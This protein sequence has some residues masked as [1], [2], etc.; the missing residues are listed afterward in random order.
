MTDFRLDNPMITGMLFY[1]RAAAQGTSRLPGTVDGRVV[2]AQDVAIGYRLFHPAPEQATNYLI[3]F[4][5]GNGEV[6]ADYDD[7]APLFFKIGAALL[8]VDYRGYG[9]STGSPLTTALLPD[10]EAVFK[11]LPEILQP[12]G[13]EA[14]PRFVMGRSLGSAPAVHLAAQFPQALRGLIVESGFA[15]APS[16]FRRLGILTQAHRHPDYP[17]NNAEKVKN[18]H[19][20]LLVIH[21]ERDTLLPVEHGQQLYDASPS[22]QRMIVRIPGA[23]HNDI[24]LYSDVYFAAL[25]QFMERCLC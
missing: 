22:D 10:A 7:I 20:P 16:L 2:V 9:W 12:V 3:I 17:F 18:I 19:L 24:L 4:F 14:L 25:K 13:L 5:H 8:A 15:D 21:G 11:A 1:P 6:A 23:G